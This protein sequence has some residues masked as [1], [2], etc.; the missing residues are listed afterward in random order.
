MDYRNY[1]TMAIDTS[2]QRSETQTEDPNTSI[3]SLKFCI[4]KTEPMA[5]APLGPADQ[6]PSICYLLI[7][8][9]YLVAAGCRLSGVVW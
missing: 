9:L 2:D 7:L 3:L 6:I 4:S 5:I 1:G 8:F